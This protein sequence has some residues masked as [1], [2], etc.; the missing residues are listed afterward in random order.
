MEKESKISI[1]KDKKLLTRKEPR[2]FMS[3]ES[4]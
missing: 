3:Y 1:I 4:Y 2:E